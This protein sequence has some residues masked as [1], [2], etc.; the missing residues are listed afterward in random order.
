MG[1]NRMKRVF[2]VCLPDQPHAHL[3]LENFQHFSVDVPLEK[4]YVLF[5]TFYCLRATF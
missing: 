5:E 1:Q 3:A 2:C 4:P